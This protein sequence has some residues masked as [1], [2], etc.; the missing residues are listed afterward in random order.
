VQNNH[1]VLVSELPQHRQRIRVMQ[2]AQY[3]QQTSARQSSGQRGQSL[4]KLRVFVNVMCTQRFQVT[5]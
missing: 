2:V 3:H 5:P 1:I 4:A